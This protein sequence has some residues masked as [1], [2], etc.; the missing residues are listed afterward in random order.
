MNT[1]RWDTILIRSGIACLA[2]EFI[3]ANILYFNALSALR[4]FWGY[5]L[6]PVGAS[7]ADMLISSWGPAMLN[8]PLGGNGLCTFLAVTGTLGII[9]GSIMRSQYRRPGAPYAYAP[10]IGVSQAPTAPGYMGGSAHGAPRL[11]CTQG[12]YANATIPLDGG[13]LIIGRDAGRCGLVLHSTE[14]SRMHARVS[15]TP[16]TGQFL[17]EDLGSTNG[18]F[19][20]PDKIK[21]AT[22]V[23]PGQNFHLGQS[24]AAFTVML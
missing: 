17:I 5:W 24:G 12:E 23:Q 18:T 8:L 7:L 20:G 4:S 2:M 19:V 10:V 15:F 3:I 22:T 9:V 21:G 14:I 6:G 13:G 1:Q 16:G 11:L